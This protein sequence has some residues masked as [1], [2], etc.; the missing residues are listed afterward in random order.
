MADNYLEKRMEDYRRATSARSVVSRRGLLFPAVTVD[1]YPAD[2]EGGEVMLRTLVA[3]GYKVSFGVTDASRGSA[4]AGKSGARYYPLM[5]EAVAAD[6]AGRGEPLAAVLMLGHDCR[7]THA[8]L[9]PG[10]WIYVGDAVPGLFCIEG[11]TPLGAAVLATA[12]AHP[13]VKL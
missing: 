9:H 7:E 3:A 1:V 4:L 2:A 6:L 8:C 10:R 5:P 11:Q 12:L 13:E